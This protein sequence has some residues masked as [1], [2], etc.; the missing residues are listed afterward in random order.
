M[1][2][3]FFSQHFENSFLFLQISVLN[4]REFTNHLMI[5]PLRLFIFC[6]FSFY[7][8]LYHPVINMM[9]LEVDVVFF[10]FS[11]CGFIYPA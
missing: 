11:P 5:F 1:S 8:C 4:Y 3:F 10:S 7:L 6:L 2:D 9:Y